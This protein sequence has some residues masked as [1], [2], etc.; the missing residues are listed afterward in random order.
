[1]GKYDALFEEEEA[2]ATAPSPAPAADKYA[3]LFEEEKPEGPSLLDRVGHSFSN[4]GHTLGSAAMGAVGLV[5][6]LDRQGNFHVPFSDLADPAYRHQ[7]ERG[8]SDVVTGGLAERAANAVDPSFAAAAPAEAEARPDARALGQVG[9]SFLPSPFRAAGEGAAAL[10]PGRGVAAGAARGLAAYEASAIPAAAMQAPE[11]KRWDAIVD[12]A[13]DPAGAL[14]SAGG[15]AVAGSDLASRAKGVIARRAEQRMVEQAIKDIAGSRETGLS[16][17][18]DRRIIARNVET[19]KDELR[20]PAAIAIADTARKDPAKAWELV[21]KRVDGLTTER[22]AT[23]AAV[24]QATGGVRK[25]DLRAWLTDEMRRLGRDPGQKTERQAIE[26]MLQDVNETWGQQAAPTVPTLKMRQYVTRLQRVAADT[27][28][29]L[30]ETRRVQLLDR[31]SG[32]AKNFLDRH[33]DEAAAASPEL[34]ESVGQLREDNRRIAAWLSV[35]DA[36]KT[37]SS[38]LETQAMV[39]NKPKSLAAGMAGAAAAAH[40]L[41]SPGAAAGAAALGA[42]PYVLPVADRAITRSL[43]GMNTAPAAAT[44]NPAAVARLIQAARA[45]ATRAQLEKQA[46][47]DGVPPELLNRIALER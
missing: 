19:L 1:M 7:L 43:A 34:R 22:E 33:L 46:Q 36:L 23:Y 18:T 21:Q 6:P 30:E 38:K 15:G 37:R 40:F 31:L 29:G 32:L 4:L 41:H 28:G 5:S 10:V 39:D 12:A 27:M 35:E 8:V 16:K 47:D 24:D 44:A 26:S 42:A 20:D 14:L 17:P 11:G 25:A 9:G 13:T 45:G 2:P 3:A